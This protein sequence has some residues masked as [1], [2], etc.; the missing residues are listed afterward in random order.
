MTRLIHLVDAAHACQ[1]LRPICGASG[2]D[3]NWTT[4]RNVHTC[5]D[6]ARLDPMASA[7]GGAIA[8]AERHPAALQGRTAPRTLPLR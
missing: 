3:L 1:D 8:G 5:P 4:L 7:D 2:D 6:C